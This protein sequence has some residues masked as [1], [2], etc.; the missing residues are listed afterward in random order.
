[1]KGSPLRHSNVQQRG[2]DML[3]NANNLTF[4]KENACQLKNYAYL[5]NRKR[6][7]WCLSSVGRASD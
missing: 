5:C 1:M 2:C 3:I 6:K 4:P 7:K